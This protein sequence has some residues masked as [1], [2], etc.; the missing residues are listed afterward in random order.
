MGSH[1]WGIPEMATHH[2]S[3]KSN[4]DAKSCILVVPM[5][6]REATVRM[7]QS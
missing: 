1:V 5:L 6:A 3:V 4:S 2:H 7:G